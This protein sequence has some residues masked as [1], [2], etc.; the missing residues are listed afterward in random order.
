M[1]MLASGRG[2]ISIAMVLCALTL[3]LAAVSAQDWPQWRGPSRNGAAP[4][5]TLPAAWP[6][7]PKQVWKVQVGEGHA[8]PIVAG[9][10]IFVF[11]RAADKEVASARDAATAKEIWRVAY[12]APYTMNSAATSHGKGPK[13]TPL[14]DR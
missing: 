6:D 4:G 3:C 13:S 11:A 5:F 12:D 1:F 10:R 2:R 7:R 14:Y 9:A 8:S